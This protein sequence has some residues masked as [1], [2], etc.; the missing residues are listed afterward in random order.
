MRF[1][2]KKQQNLL[3]QSTESIL[4]LH[5][6][7]IYAH[8]EIYLYTNPKYQN[9]CGSASERQNHI[10]FPSS[11]NYTVDTQHSSCYSSIN[12]GTEHVSKH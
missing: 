5:H 11:I 7:H 9:S 3:Q 10:S 8:T 2:G 6:I 1:E 12:L 4:H